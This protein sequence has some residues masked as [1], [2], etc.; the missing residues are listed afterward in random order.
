MYSKCYEP[1]VSFKEIARDRIGRGEFLQGHGNIG[2]KRKMA[3]C[4]PINALDWALVFSRSEKISKLFGCRF[5]NANSGKVEMLI[6]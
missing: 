5:V 3:D 1:L 4:S 6:D 2:K